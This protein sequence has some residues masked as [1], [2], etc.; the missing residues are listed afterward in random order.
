MSE[1]RY[2]GLLRAIYNSRAG[3]FPFEHEY[4]QFIEAVLESHL[5]L[6]DQLR[7][8]LARDDLDISRYVVRVAHT[9]R[10]H[11]LAPD[12]I[13]EFKTVD[14]LESRFKNAI[15]LALDYLRHD[16]IPAFLLA[17][18]QSHE[19]IEHR[20]TA[21]QSLRHA[22]VRPELALHFLHMAED[23]SE[24]AE[25]RRYAIEG[26]IRH[27]RRTVIPLLVPFLE[28]KLGQIRWMALIGFEMYGH[29]LFAPVIAPLIDDPYQGDELMTI[30]ALAQKILAKWA[31][32]DNQDQAL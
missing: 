29:A 12:L 32:E 10:I 16:D 5:P 27:G 11:E 25:M 7:L 15:L 28:D 17:V 14:T 22:K 6:I 4:A 1:V 24:V 21:I 13:H 18:M 23:L 3:R 30:G 31:S 2:R 8:I 19:A 20:R 26:L 9:V